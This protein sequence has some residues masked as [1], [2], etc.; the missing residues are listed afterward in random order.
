MRLLFANLTS[1]QCLRQENSKTKVYILQN[2][3]PETEITCDTN[4]KYYKTRPVKSSLTNG[5]IWIVDVILNQI[6]NG[7]FAFHNET[8]YHFENDMAYKRPDIYS[9]SLVDKT[10]LHFNYR[11]SIAKEINNIL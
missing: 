7:D 9:L 3:P 10:T 6:H 11:T 1:K 2:N 8:R 4:I 5:F